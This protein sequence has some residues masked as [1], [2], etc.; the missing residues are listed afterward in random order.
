MFRAWCF[1]SGTA[2]FWF[3][4]PRVRGGAA[5]NRTPTLIHHR[6]P[7]AG[8]AGELSVVYMALPYLR[9]RKLYSVDMPNAMNFAF[10]VTALFRLV[11][12]A[13]VFGLPM[14]RRSPAAPA[15][16]GALTTACAQLYGYMLEQRR[17]NLAPR[18]STV[19]KKRS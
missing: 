6:P 17:R 14:V 2:G 19:K 10:S 15:R 3:Y 11:S 5:R 9:Q 7:A 16:A 12:L 4:I 13:Y 8:V 1:G 18:P